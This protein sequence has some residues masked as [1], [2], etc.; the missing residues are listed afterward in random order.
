MLVFYSVSPPSIP[1]RRRS[2]VIPSSSPVNSSL[3]ESAATAA[4]LFFAP[5]KSILACSHHRRDTLAPAS[6]RTS[7]RRPESVASEYSARPCSA[8]LLC[9]LWFPWSLFPLLPP[10]IVVIFNSHPPVSLATSQW[11]IGRTCVGNYPGPAP[12]WGFATTSPSRTIT[13]PAS[14]L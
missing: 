11:A 3:F 2:M 14:P 7:H 5:S 10:P 12:S 13:P 1:D 4:A 6:N 9:I 8:S